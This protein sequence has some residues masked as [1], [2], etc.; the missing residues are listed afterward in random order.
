MGNCSSHERPEVVYE[1]PQPKEDLHREKVLGSVR[2]NL[3]ALEEYIIKLRNEDVHFRMPR[4]IFLMNSLKDITPIIQKMEN[5]PVLVS[6]AVMAQFDELFLR[7]WKNDRTE[8]IEALD[9]INNSL[10]NSY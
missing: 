2:K 6:E 5:N 9:Q 1:T 7:L 8:Y 4:I 3:K 10:R